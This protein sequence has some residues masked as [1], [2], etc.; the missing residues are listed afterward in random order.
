MNTAVSLVARNHALDFARMMA[1][2]GVVVIH[3]GP[4]TPAAERGV[5][6]FLNFCVPFFLFTSV[7]FFWEE[8]ART[9]EPVRALIRRW[10]R[11]LRPYVAWTLIY[12]T[13]RSVGAGLKGQSLSGLLT[14]KS[15][16]E[17]IG[18]G[19]GA[20]QLYFLPLLALALGLAALLVPVVNRAARLGRWMPVALF[21]A[22]VGLLFTHQGDRVAAAETALGKLLARYFDWV[23]WML[24]L[25]LCAAVFA[26]SMAR[27]ARP[28]P[29]AAWALLAAA[30]ALDLA[31]V[32]RALPYEWRFHGLLLAALVL[33]ACLL[34]KIPARL[35][36]WLEQLLGVSFGVFLSHHLVI[37]CVEIFDR[38]RGGVLTQ[39]YTLATLAL[40]STGVFVV[41]ASFTMGVQRHAFLRRWLLGQ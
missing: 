18:A 36:P 30:V 10:P 27:V 40:V 35:S 17:I 38:S 33:T 2:F 39:P 7:Y 32:W 9:D 21:A 15:L 20:V 31:I 8:T 26:R 24:P 1:A 19:G 5:D 12:V 25:V 22:V 34:A 23:T 6:F 13:V 14:P 28:R 37:E 41:A 16:V 4:G 11:L 3:C 29:W